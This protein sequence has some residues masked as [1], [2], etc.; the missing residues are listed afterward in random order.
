[1]TGIAIAKLA[2]WVLIQ[3]EAQRHVGMEEYHDRPSSTVIN[4]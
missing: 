3:K 1:M 2:A 4:L